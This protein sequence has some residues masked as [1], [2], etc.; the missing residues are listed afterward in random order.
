MFHHNGKTTS[1]ETPNNGTYQA[2]PPGVP[3]RPF[4]GR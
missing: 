1:V 3:G 2:E 4:D